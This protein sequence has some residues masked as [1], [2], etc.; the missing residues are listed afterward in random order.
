MTS[1]P[2]KHTP[3]P[4]PTYYKRLI[5]EMERFWHLDCANLISFK[6]SLFS[7]TFVYFPKMFINKVLQGF[8]QFFNFGE[9]WLHIF[10]G[11]TRGPP[12]IKEQRHSLV[13]LMNSAS[14]MLHITYLRSWSC[15]PNGIETP[16]HVLI[17]FSC[18][19]CGSRLE[20][21]QAA[22][23]EAKLGGE[24]FDGEDKRERASSASDKRWCN[25]Q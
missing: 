24:L 3:S 12:G 1:T 7:N 20:T 10:K 16:I 18:V 8:D 6:F 21:G 25:N 4:W 14:R 2:S 5:V 13:E 15:S 17:P 23:G 11:T 9:Q 22:G 19:G